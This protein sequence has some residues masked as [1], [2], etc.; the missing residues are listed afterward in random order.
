MSQALVEKGRHSPTSQREH[1]SPGSGAG[2]G[3]SWL[4][5][6]ARSVSRDT[7]PREVSSGDVTQVFPKLQELV[8]LVIE[9]EQPDPLPCLA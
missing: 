5:V 9:M 7:R 6:W 3:V 4:A 8:F 2:W 1:V